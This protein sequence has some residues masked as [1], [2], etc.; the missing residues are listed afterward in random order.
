MT[1]RPIYIL[2]SAILLALNGCESDVYPLGNVLLTGPSGT[3]SHVI[4]DNHTFAFPHRDLQPPSIDPPGTT[5]ALSFT[6][7]SGEAPRQEVI[8]FDLDYSEPI[9]V[10][11]RPTIDYVPAPV[12]YV[13]VPAGTDKTYTFD[14]APTAHVI[15]YFKRADRVR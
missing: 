4:D 8:G 14:A 9:V 2:T 15:R 12:E 6:H 1:A 13:A 7:P 11:R 5:H 10:G 3:S